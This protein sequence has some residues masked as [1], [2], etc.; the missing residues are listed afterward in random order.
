[1]L[2]PLVVILLLCALV[3]LVYGPIGPIYNYVMQTQSPAHL[4]GR[5]VGVMTSLA[6][7]AGPIGFML[8]GPL[9]DAFGLPTT[10]L[11]LAVPMI[12]IGLVALR[13][14]SLHELDASPT[15]DSG[16]APSPSQ[17]QT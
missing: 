10:F 5:V 3:G 16:L 8:A 17:P 2:P 1:V 4:R 11:A 7:A 15:P 9:A 12:M 13:L 14:Q 6:Y